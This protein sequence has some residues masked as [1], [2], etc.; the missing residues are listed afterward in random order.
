MTVLKVDK[1]CVRAICN[2]PNRTNSVQMKSFAPWHQLSL[3]VQIPI[4]VVMDHT[5]VYL[6][7]INAKLAPVKVHSLTLI[8]I[9][10]HLYP[11][12]GLVAKI[13]FH[14]LMEGAW[15]RVT[16]WLHSRVLALS[17]RLEDLANSVFRQKLLPIMLS[18]LQ[19]N[20]KASPVQLAQ[21]FVSM[22]SV[23]TAFMTAHKS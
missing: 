12:K 2:V 15:W 18:I 3:G 19:L 20:C 11:T 10:K 16:A 9:R 4:F 14:A 8:L 5:C 13:W 6:T 1:F 21:L 22:D 23:V 7:R 17:S